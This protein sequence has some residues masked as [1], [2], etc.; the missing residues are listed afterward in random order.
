MGFLQALNDITG[1]LLAV[2]QVTVDTDQAPAA[3]EA[4]RVCCATRHPN[5]V[6]SVAASHFHAGPGG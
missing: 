6:R 2:K 4:L 5:L 3:A 1:E